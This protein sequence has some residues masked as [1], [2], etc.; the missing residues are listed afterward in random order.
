MTVLSTEA[1]ALRMMATRLKKAIEAIETAAALLDGLESVEADKGGEKL[2]GR[3]LELARC[4]VDN[5][6]MTRSE[7]EA[8][9]PTMPPGT[10]SHL[11][12]RDP[13][14]TRGADRRWEYKPDAGA[15]G[16]G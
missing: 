3:K 14:F 13:D 6:S 2:T 5:G 12:S 8:N 4:F 15:K 1:E 11:L 7:L 16:E 9:L 10:M